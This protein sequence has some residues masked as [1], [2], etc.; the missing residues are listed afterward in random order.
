MNPHSA[1]SHRSLLVEAV[2]H[3]L[4]GLW[5]TRALPLPE[6]DADHMREMA[7]RATGLD[8]YGDPWFV[9]PL[10]QLL[11]SLREEAE[12]NPVGRFGAY[13]QIAKTLR[14][15]LWTEHWLRAHPEIE[16]RSL[17]RPV[18]IVGPMR[19][20]TTRLHRLL[21][22][23]ARFAHLRLFETICPAPAPN[24]RRGTAR[25]CDA[26][27]A[28]AAMILAAVHRFNPNTAV[29][30]PS[31]PMQPEEELGLLV[32]SM[33]GMK[34][35]AQ[36]HV[37]GYG[38]WSESQDATPAYR[39]MARL[40]QLVGWLRGEDDA[41]PWVLK[42]PQHT[43]DLPA[44]LRIFPDARIIF[45]HRRPKAVVGSSCSL[46]WNQMIIHSDRV[47][48]RRV[49]DEWLRKTA[50]QIDRM[51]RSRET[52]A[53]DQR[54]DVHYEDMERDWLAVMKRIYRFLDMDIAPALPAMERY[55]A[56]A[57]R[58]RRRHPHRYDLGSFGL[59][60]RLVDDQFADY[61]AEFD[62][63]TDPEGRSGTLAAAASPER[64]PSA[65]RARV[66]RSAVTTP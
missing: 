13:G 1:L 27:R 14:E 50:L 66:H 48:P 28:K 7:C 18:I 2:G 15:R 53:D 11:L 40:L 59:D 37:P 5:K 12:L 30:H 64:A 20:G 31:S 29:I 60:Q 25:A 39:Q 56:N 19:S 6:F 21:A 8:D 62:L 35:E 32:A 44:L 33:W 61:A 63:P 26:R 17:R 54:I 43:L 9:R 49:G 47:D 22:A 46:V 4:T 38:R 16:R 52:M 10:E 58:Q 34:H 3:V 51:R 65:S 57:D 24:F 45:T 23:D 36:W 42:T 41:R 55:V